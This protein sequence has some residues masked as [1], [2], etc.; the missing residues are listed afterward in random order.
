M[1]QSVIKYIYEQ[2]FCLYDSQG[3]WPLLD[4]QGTNPTKTGSMKGYHPGDYSYPRNDA[5]RFEICIGAL[6]TQNTNWVNVEKALRNLKEQKLL[7][8][9]TMLSCTDAVLKQVIRPAGYFNQKARKLKEFSSFYLQLNG[10]TPTREQLLALWGVGPETADS[11]LLYAYNIPTFVV[12]AY[13]RRILTNLKLAP[14]TASYDDI[15][16]LFESALEQSPQIYQEY[17]ALLVE[18]AKRYY[19]KE[20]T[21]HECPLAKEFLYKRK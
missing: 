9:K 5:Q 1:N 2:L 12:D 15:K 18:H 3:W 7:T 8:P 10:K 11:I 16:V 19:Q 13:T 4:C 17:H 14:S 21:Q 20:E 6:L